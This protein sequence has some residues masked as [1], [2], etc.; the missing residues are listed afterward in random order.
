MAKKHKAQE[1][2]NQPQNRSRQRREWSE[3][4]FQH[5]TGVQRAPAIITK[6]WKSER[7]QCRW[8]GGSGKPVCGGLG[9]NEK[10]RT[11]NASILTASRTYE[12]REMARREQE[13]RMLPLPTPIS[14][15]QKTILFLSLIQQLF[16]GCL[17]RDRQ[18][19][20]WDKSVN[21]TDKHLLP[22]R[23]FHSSRAV[24]VSRSCLTPLRPHGLYSWWNSSGQILKWVTPFPTPGD[25]PNLEIEPR[26]PAFLVDLQLSLKGSPSRPE[27][28]LK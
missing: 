7:Q 9:S 5:C 6:G 27:G 17:Q 20:V 18:L 15:I 22:W 26:S 25:L 4:Y 16:M 1:D 28:T 14:L 21:K 24:K 10:A 23:C 12:S 13:W 8:S 19:Q 3:Q 11:G 2:W